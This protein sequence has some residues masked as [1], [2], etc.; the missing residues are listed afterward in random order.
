MRPLLATSDVAAVLSEGRTVLL[1][2]LPARTERSTRRFLQPHPS[3][4]LLSPTPPSL[5]FLTQTRVD[6]FQHVER[7]EE[8]GAGSEVWSVGRAR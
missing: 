1:G 4:T 6:P 5:P 3:L 8:E 2:G 7:A